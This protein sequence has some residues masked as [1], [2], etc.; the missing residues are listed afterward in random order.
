MKYSTAIKSY[1][2]RENTLGGAVFSN[3]GV[4]GFLLASVRWKKV[5]NEQGFSLIELIMVIVIL[6][7][8]SISVIPKLAEKS[9]FA[10]HAF[11]NDTL[12]ALRYAQKLAVATHCDVQIS[13]S[14]NSYVLKRPAT[15]SDCGV[16]TS[17]FTLSVVNPGTGSASYTGSESGVTLSSTSSIVFFALG[18]ASTDAT[19]TVA[20]NTIEVEQKTGFAYEP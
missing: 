7:T 15:I 10:E 1:H 4:T 5:K 14:A 9:D 2:F 6:G 11:F 19:I 3:V 13:F 20:G 8:I 18:D 12:N 16:S 17:S